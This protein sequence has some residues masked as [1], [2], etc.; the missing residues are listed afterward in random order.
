MTRRS[1]TGIMQVSVQSLA[2]LETLQ[3]FTNYSESHCVR[4]TAEVHIKLRRG[5]FSSRLPSTNM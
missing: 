5:L 2:K 3:D 4:E 1:K